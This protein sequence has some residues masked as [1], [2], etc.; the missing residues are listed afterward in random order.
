MSNG[1]IALIGEVY[2]DI[3][4]EPS[5]DNSFMRLGGVIHAARA[6]GAIGKDYDLLYTSPFYLEEEIEN[7]SLT[8]GAKSITNIGTVIGTPNVAFVSDPTEA[9]NQ[10]YEF[11]L[12]DKYQ[13]EIK[14]EQLKKH[15]L[16]DDIT[17]IVIFP[18]AFNLKPILNVCSQC[19]AK[20]HIDIANEVQTLDIFS[21]LDRKLDVIFLS[22]SSGLFI[23]KYKG[24]IDQFCEACLGT[25]CRA[26][27]FKENRGGVRVFYEDK[28]SKPISSGTQLRTIVHS[29][30]VGDCFDVSFVSLSHEYADE[31]ALAYS[32]W[33]SAEYAS[34]YSFQKFKSKCNEVFSLTPDDIVHLKGVSL[35]W[36]ERCNKNIYIAA[37]DFD[38]VDRTQI[39]LIKESLE[40]HN[41]S[42]RLPIRENGQM[43]ENSTR[44][45][46]QEFFEADMELLKVCDILLAV[47]IYN[48]PGTLIEIGL[49]YGMGKPVIVFD[50]FD[51]AENLML[52]QLP[53]LISSN[54]DAVIAKVFELLSK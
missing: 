31:V 27:V 15:L 12:K 49:A 37:P 39:N 34:T 25:I 20:V 47:M 3:S 7:Y 13:C 41:F 29:V 1:K 8:H 40:Y 48:D 38:F 19:K 21:D 44:I 35:P 5:K 14:V 32:T 11:P 30:G 24:L 46:K 22:T 4:L 51:K 43:E 53:N 9:G 2:L 16:D 52:T 10:G 36:E 6:L 42:P 18:G 17:D 28:P 26:V 33:I 23:D 45:E 50:P 54:L